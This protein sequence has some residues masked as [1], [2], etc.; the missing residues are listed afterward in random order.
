M[1]TDPPPFTSA[2]RTKS[3]RHWN[4]AEQAK[5]PAAATEGGG[6]DRPTA[7]SRLWQAR[8]VLA[9]VRE[10]L[11]ILLLVALVASLARS[12]WSVLPSVSVS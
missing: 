6:G 3:G 10:I 9:C 12:G 5:V 1:P 4:T 11:V 2:S 8:Q 7:P